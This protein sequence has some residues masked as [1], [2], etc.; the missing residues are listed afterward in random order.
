MGV[1]EFIAVENVLVT[2]GTRPP[3]KQEAI[4]FNR[5][6]FPLLGYFLRLLEHSGH[7]SENALNEI[8]WLLERGIIFDLKDLPEDQRLTANADYQQSLKLEDTIQ[9]FVKEFAKK[10][11]IGKALRLVSAMARN[12]PSPVLHDP[13]LQNFFW[14]SILF[15]ENRARL[16]AIQLRELEKLDAYPI[17]RLGFNP[18][19]QSPASKTEVLQIV[20]NDLPIPD[21]TTSWEQI[22]EY[23]SDP[24]S[25]AKFLDLRNWM[26]EVAKAELKPVEIEEK[27][28]HLM[29]L[30]QRHMNIH[31]MKTNTG[32]VETI[33]ITSAEML[34]DLL[35]FKWG[36]AAQAL[37]SLKRRQVALL[38]GELTSPGREVAY[39]V[40]AKETFP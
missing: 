26:S 19:E 34:G 33:V 7:I 4:I 40:K 13:E 2:A 5:I 11:G 3:L 25:I 12:K 30:Y 31:R 35:S 1:R 15:I 20:L 8:N 36:K 22:I 32:T 24:D 18:M 37:F 38:E 17:L 14:Q 29:S 16:G 39:I 28:E 9:S 10:G 6:G 23:R 27:L 21:A